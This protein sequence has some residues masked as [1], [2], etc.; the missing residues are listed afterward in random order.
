M[1]CTLMSP[2]FK[3]HDSP[4]LR[5]LVENR[6]VSSYVLNLLIIITIII[7]AQKMKFCLKNFF[8][9]CEQICS[10]LRIWSHLLKKS[11]M[12]DSISCAVFIAKLFA[13]FLQIAIYVLEVAIYIF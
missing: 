13:C 6:A 1:L 12:E 7:A 8:S 9:K 2:C 5:K 4:F 3:F 10:F 11:L